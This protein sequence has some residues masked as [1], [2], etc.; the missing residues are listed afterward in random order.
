MDINSLASQVK[1]NCNISDAQYWGLYSPCG[2]LLRLRD[3]YRIEKGLRPW[4]KAGHDEI[5]VWIGERERLWRELESLD[6]QRIEMNGRKYQPFYVGGIN[7]VLLDKGFIYGAGYGNLLKPTFFL[8]GLSKKM[9]RGRYNI[10]I[11][12]REFARDLSASPAML[13]GNRIVARQETMECFLWA[14]FEEMRSKKYGGA[15]VHAFS[16]YGISKDREL[17]PDRLENHVTGIARE[18]LSTCI[19]HE[20]GEASQRTLLGRWWK[21]L[22]VKLSYCRAELFIRAL[23]DI[24]SDTCAAGM[25]AHIIKERKTGSLAFYVALLGGFRKIIFPEIVEAYDEFVTERR[26]PLIEKAR[27]EGYRNAKGYVRELKGIVDKGRISREEIE[28]QLV[29]KVV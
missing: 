9:N 18:E 11:S 13:Q 10:Y 23:K 25:L 2:L 7:A 1:H 17:A 14:K 28:R 19:Y 4:E 3:L 29:R 5:K 6:F 21:E 26:W 15:L 27:K 8:A 22:V 12:G 20:L 16:E 24:L